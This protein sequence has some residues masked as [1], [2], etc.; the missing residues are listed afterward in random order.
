VVS[1]F[2][3][4]VSKET[5]NKYNNAMELIESFQNEEEK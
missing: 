5:S 2:D 1:V 4:M 3:E